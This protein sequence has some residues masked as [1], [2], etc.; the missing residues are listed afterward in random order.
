VAET[1][2]SRFGLVQ[3][4]VG[5]DSP[6]RVDFNEAFL[7]LENR[8]AYDD[9]VSASSLPVTNVVA[10]RYALVAPGGANKTLYRRSDGGTWDYA[11]GNT[12]PDT[13]YVRPYSGV[14]AGGPARSSAAL[15]LSHPDGSGG[16][17]ATFAYDGSAALG[18]TLRV[19]DLNDAAAGNL[20]VG[21][22]VTADAATTG[23]VHVRTRADGERG[24]VVRAHGSGA[25]SLVAVQTSAGSDVLTLDA[26][27]RMQQRSAAAF[28][29]ASVPSDSMLAVAP[30][31]GADSVTNGLTLH[32]QPTPADTKTILRVLRQADDSAALLQLGRD[33]FTIGR[34]P[35]GSSS[36]NGGL[37][38]SGRQLSARASG[39]SGDS[40]LWKLTRADITDPS[41]GSL[42]EPVSTL[43]R[44]AGLTRVPMTVSQALNTGAVALTL[45]RY[46]DLTQNFLEL[47][48]MGAAESVEV[49]GSWDSEGRA[50][51]GTRWVGAGLMRDARQSLRHVNTKRYATPG[52]DGF[53][54]GQQINP[55]ASYTYTFNSMQMRSGSVADLNITLQTEYTL[56]FE[57]D[58]FGNSSLYRISVSVNG[59]SF[60]LIETREFWGVAV[61][62]A[63]RPV[64]VAGTAVTTLGAIPAGA[65][66]QVR[67]Q[68]T[69]NV[70]SSSAAMFLR[71][72]YLN[73]EES[74]VAAYSGP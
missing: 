40:V 49:V 71:M 10:G 41:N 48:R 70:V 8:A 36:A 54:V 13:F 12:S 73:V 74:L 68:V 30:T 69:N 18:G 45:K 31:S 59:G 35:W 20:V 56:A 46:T 55:T 72:L 34:L 38:L 44:T 60:T 29:G 50:L 47:H 67:V 16:A 52:V 6:S 11:G 57:T 51:S 5:T 58:D 61:T 2:T 33:N 4:G 9:G 37:S 1:R 14:G 32:G 65:T 25:G 43:G 7:N 19:Y 3:W 63:S 62:S 24:L 15:V 17:G 28:G 27:G 22:T 64:G 39:Y 21:S 23:R 53:T 26:V 42:D 66:V